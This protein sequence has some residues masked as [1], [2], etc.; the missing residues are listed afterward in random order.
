MAVQPRPTSGFCAMEARFRALPT[1]AYSRR[2]E[3]RSELV[4]AHLP[5]T[6]LIC[7]AGLLLAAAAAAA[8]RRMPLETAVEKKHTHSRQRKYRPIPTQTRDMHTVKELL[9]LLLVLLLQ[10]FQS[11]QPSQLPVS[12]V[13]LL[14]LLLQAAEMLAITMYNRTSPQTTSSKPD[15]RR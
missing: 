15:E 2:L 4:M 9:H 1:L 6:S 3:P 12:Q 13:L 5:L 14:L 11:L 10:A 7:V 8:Y